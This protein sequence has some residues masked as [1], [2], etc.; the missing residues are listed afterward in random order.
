METTLKAI[1]FTLIGSAPG[2]IVGLIRQIFWTFGVQ[3][4]N[5]VSSLIYA[6][7]LPLSIL[8]LTIL[9][10]QRQGKAITPLSYV[11]EPGG[12]SPH[13]MSRPACHPRSRPRSSRTRVRGMRWWSWS[14][15]S[16]ACGR[17]LAEGWS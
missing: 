10:R 7:V 13:L 2:P 1:L 4:T 17:S 16:S 6:A 11:I 9:Y 3:A 8:G 12:G 5:V 15:L 14:S